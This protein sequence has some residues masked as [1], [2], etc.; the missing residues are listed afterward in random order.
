MIVDLR[1]KLIQLW[2][3]TPWNY[4]DG[5]EGHHSGGLQIYFDH[6]GLFIVHLKHSTWAFLHTIPIGMR[7]P[8][9]GNEPQ[10]LVRSKTM[11]QL[12]S[13]RDKYTSSAS[14]VT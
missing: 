14:K 12:L 7:L 1:S 5:W 4:A 2:G 13:H 6:L 8:R 9:P 10:S 11:P 3:L